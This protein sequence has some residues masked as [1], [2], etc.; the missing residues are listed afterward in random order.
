MIFTFI[1][2]LVSEFSYI[3]HTIISDYYV[4]SI[5]TICSTLLV[6]HIEMVKF[7]SKHFTRA[8]N[9]LS[10]AQFKIDL[11]PNYL[12]NSGKVTELLNA[13]MMTSW[14]ILQIFI[15]CELGDRITDQFNK[16]PNAIYHRNW[17]TFL[18]EIQRMIPMI[19]MAAQQPVALQG[20]ANL[21][22]IRESFRKVDK[23]FQIK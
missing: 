6:V 7:K 10:S 18:K 21:K 4:W 3:Y 23:S 22:F 1:F 9:F 20:F 13:L 11:L 14:T 12:Q 15:F 19:L 5:L 16:I 2:R 8:N 17:Y